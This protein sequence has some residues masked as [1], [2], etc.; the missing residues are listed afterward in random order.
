VF[1]YPPSARMTGSEPNLTRI[2]VWCGFFLCKNGKKVKGKGM[3]FGKKQ[4]SLPH[5]TI[6][7]RLRYGEG[8]ECRLHHTNGCHFG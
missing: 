6:H 4:D 1:G 5:Y 3:N 7:L 8:N 2:E